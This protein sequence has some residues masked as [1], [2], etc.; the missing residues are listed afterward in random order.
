MHYV[1]EHAFFNSWDPADAAQVR[2]ISVAAGQVERIYGAESF[3]Q[4][5]TAKVVRT[6]KL[7][8][9]WQIYDELNATADPALMFPLSSYATGGTHPQLSWYQHSRTKYIASDSRHYTAALNRVL[10]LEHQGWKRGRQYAMTSDFGKGY[11]R[12]TTG[13]CGTIYY[14]ASKKRE[15]IIPFY[16]GFFGVLMPQKKFIPNPLIPLDIEISLNPYALYSTL[17]TTAGGKRNYKITRFEIVSHVLFFD[18]AIDAQLEA[19]IS[20]QGLYLHCNSF[21]QCQITPTTNNS[22]TVPNVLSIGTSLQ[23]INSIH[24]LFYYN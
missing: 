17:T 14:P 20:S 16:S 21:F 4:H 24:L 6:E 18:S 11:S 3:L 12:A 5:R 13:N 8:H 1:G 9:S 15:F 2:D 22:T 23:S 19:Q 10:N 7:F